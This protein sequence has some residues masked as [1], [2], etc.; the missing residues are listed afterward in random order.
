MATNINIPIPQNP[1]GENYPWRDWFQK[2][3]NKVFGT[4]SIQDANSVV[5]TGGTIDNS[6]IGLINPSTGNFTDLTTST[7]AVNGGTNGQLL[8][9]RTSDHRF[10]P[11]TLTAGTNITIT[12]AASSITIAASGGFY[13]IDGGFYN[14]VYGGTTALNA[15]GP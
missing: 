6:S 10:V 9:G 1:I 8:I 13:N 3:S 4:L 14:S 7:L 15:G 5:I 12:N 2:L 11:A